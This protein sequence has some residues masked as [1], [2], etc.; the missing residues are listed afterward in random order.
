MMDS[1][2]RG[3]LGEQIALAY[4]ALE[5]YTCLARRW[6]RGGGE[7]DLVMTRPGLVVFVEVKLRGQGSVATATESVTRAQLQRL[8]ALARRWV[9]EQGGCRLAQRLDVI[10]IDHAGEGRGLVLHHFPQA[11]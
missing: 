7:L 10:A 5:G 11:G 8:R 6:R 3:R 9:H 4:Y 2:T 1:A